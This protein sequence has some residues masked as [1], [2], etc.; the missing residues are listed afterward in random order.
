[1]MLT[2]KQNTEILI[3]AHDLSYEGKTNRAIINALQKIN[4]LTIHTVGKNSPFNGHNIV[5]H[6]YI[7][8]KEVLVELYKQCDAMLFTSEVDNY[9]L[10]I[11]ESL[12]LNTPVIAT[13]SQASN[14][15]LERVGGRTAKNITEIISIIE[16]RTWLEI[17][18]DNQSLEAVSNR[19]AGYFSIKR[20]MQ[21]YIDVYRSL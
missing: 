8:T 15:V 2:N 1:T 18:Y 5:N 20:M 13:N 9:P 10:V 7:S 17:L 6:G 4:N 19:A 3:I 21:E 12:I 11:C 16:N 14:E